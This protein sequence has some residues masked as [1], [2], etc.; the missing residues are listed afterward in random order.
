MTP[1]SSAPV[2]TVDRGNTTL[3]CCLVADGG[4]RRARLAP[5]RAAL[6]EFLD[7]GPSPVR[8]AGVTVVRYGLADVAE[9]LAARAIPFATAGHDLACPLALDYAEPATLGADRWVAAVA[10]RA[11]YG[12][13]LI[14]DCGTAVTV[15]A[16]TQE[17]RFR[18][19]AIAP[20]L[21]AM[22]VGLAHAAPALPRPPLGADAHAAAPL[23]FP[24]ECSTDAVTAGVHIGCAA[25]VEGL[26][27]RLAA[28]VGLSQAPVV[29]TGGDADIVLR[30]ATRSFE[31]V[32]DLVH[33]GLR[34]LL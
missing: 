29:L 31:S 8:A 2:L 11:L 19:G 1:N 17:G 15:D 5:T 4:V 9:E 23:A 13:A 33:R 34:E 26:V 32:P 27:A 25:L 30:Y 21:T 3:D 10:A 12:D 28:Y 20:G 14:V 24:T 22:A 18:G 6:V 7:A 16:V